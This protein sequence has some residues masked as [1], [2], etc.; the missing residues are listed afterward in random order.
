MI[1]EVIWPIVLTLFFL[2]LTVLI[3]LIVP[4]VLQFKDT[5]TKLNQALDTI[6]NELPTILDN[7]NDVTKTINLATNKV[8]GTVERFSELETII[9]QQIK[10]PIKTIASIVATLL[11]LVTTLVGRRKSK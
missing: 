8:E 7:V 6:N 9:T 4:L 10:I 3:I 5:I 1:W 2:G 11:K